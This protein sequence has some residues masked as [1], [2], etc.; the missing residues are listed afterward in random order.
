[1]SEV[2]KD[3]EYQDILTSHD[4]DGIREYDNPMPFWWKAVFVLTVIWA[5]FY[6]I[7]VEFG[8]INDYGE[9]LRE[10]TV[11]VN[12]VRATT[13]AAAPVVDEALI[14][15]SAGD[16]TRVAAG[17][18]VFTTM[19]ASC[20]NQ[21]GQGLIGPNLTDK[22]WIHGGS[23]MDIHKII[24]EG[25]A[26][27]GMPPWGNVISAD[28]AINVTAFIATLQGTNPA[29]PKEAQGDVYPAEK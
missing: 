18:K 25:V 26:A 8:Y 11:A 23:P 3:S 4:Y 22:F 15:A 27:K 5:P 29:N 28:D 21:E 20:H 6:V 19:C 24:V 14:V 12:A 13:M 10:D 16:A 7:G 2:K 1:M 9:D 17:Q